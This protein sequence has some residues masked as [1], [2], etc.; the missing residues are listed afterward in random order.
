VENLSWQSGAEFLLKE[1]I[2]AGL[3]IQAIR[4]SDLSR[5]NVDTTVQTKA[6]RYPTDVRL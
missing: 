1:T 4:P 6:I 3:K 5:V 2:Q